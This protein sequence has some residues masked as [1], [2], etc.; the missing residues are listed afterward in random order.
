MAEQSLAKLY[1]CFQVVFVV[2]NA[3]HHGILKGDAPIRTLEVFEERRF[4]LA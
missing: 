3:V 4:K 2:V 1:E